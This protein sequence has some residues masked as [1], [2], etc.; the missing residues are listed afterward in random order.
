MERAF[1]TLDTRDGSAAL[2]PWLFRIAHNEA[3]NVLRRRRPTADLR[4]A[5]G[6]AG[7]PLERCLGGVLPAA[8]DRTA[9]PAANARLGGRRAAVD[10]G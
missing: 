10:H 6:V 5:E 9:R 7:P 3:V 8:G 4:L 2:R 1:F